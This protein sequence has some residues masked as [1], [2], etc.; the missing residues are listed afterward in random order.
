M[1][2]QKNEGLI[3][4]LADIYEAKVHHLRTT[5]VRDKPLS[6]GVESYGRGFQQGIAEVEKRIISRFYDDE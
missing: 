5:A 3:D 6:S 4:A 1:R 2:D